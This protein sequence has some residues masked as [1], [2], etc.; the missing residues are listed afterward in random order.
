MSTPMP[1]DNLNEIGVLKRRE[2]EARVLMPVL[3]ALGSQYGRAQVFETARKVIIDVARAQ[4]KE[5][6]GRMGGDSLGHFATALEDWKKGKTAASQALFGLVM[7]ATGGKANPAIVKRL[8]EAKLP[9][10]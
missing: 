4:G 7:R 5:L 10:I 6:A 3:E 9:K 1:P 8:L 2:I